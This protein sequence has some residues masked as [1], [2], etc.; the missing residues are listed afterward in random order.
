MAGKGLVGKLSG[1]VCVCACTCVYACMHVC[2]CAH[3]CM[4]VC[5]C[6]Y[7]CVRE[8]FLLIFIYSYLPS[9]IMSM[10]SFS[11]GSSVCLYVFVLGCG[12]VQGIQYYDY[13]VCWRF[14]VHIFV[15]LVKC[16]MLTLY[17][18]CSRF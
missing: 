3:T 7:L 1:H 13:V 9:C 16:G 8:F 4:H 18:C 5:V 17:I 14:Y 2:V 15:D 11:G 6:V 10:E 12:V